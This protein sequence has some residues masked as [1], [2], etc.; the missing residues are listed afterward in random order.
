MKEFEERLSRAFRILEL[1]DRRRAETCNWELGSGI[2]RSVAD[3]VLLHIDW[4]K[5]A[6]EQGTDDQ[7]PV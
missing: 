7:P 2:E 1:I 6:P 5:V 4:V 3:G